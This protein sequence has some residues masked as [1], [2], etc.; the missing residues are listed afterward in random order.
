MD[1]VTI[2]SLVSGIIS[3]LDFSKEA[4]DICQQLVKDGS[5][6]KHRS[7]GE[8]A[9]SLDSAIVDLDSPLDNCPSDTISREDKVLVDLCHRCRDTASVIRRQLVKLKK[10]GGILD[11]IKKTIQTMR[12]N[13]FI[14]QKKKEL[15]G[16]ER[17]LNTRILVRLDTRAVQQMQ[18]FDRLL[19]RMN[20]LSI[21]A[22]DEKSS[23]GDRNRSQIYESIMDSLKFPEI[24]SR[25]EQILD[26]YRTTYEWIFKSS[27]EMDTDVPS[28]WAS[29]MDWLTAST[30]TIYWVHGKAGSGKST[31]MSFIEQDD[32][33][34]SAL[35]AWTGPDSVLLT[36]SFFFWE[37]GTDMQK[38]VKGLL[39]SLLCQILGKAPELLTIANISISEAKQSSSKSELPA[40]HALQVWTERRLSATLTKIMDASKNTDTHFCFFID[41]LDEFVGDTDVLRDIVK[42]LSSY[43]NTEVCVSSRPEQAFLRYFAGVP[44]LRLQDLTSKDIEFYVNDRLGSELLDIQQK[45]Y[46]CK[47]NLSFPH[48]VKCAPGLIDEIVSKASGVFLWVKIVT[49]QLL[50]GL[51]D[52][53]DLIELYERLKELPPDVE[54]LYGHMLGKL[55]DSYLKESSRYF[56]LLIAS[57]LGPGP[58]GVTLFQMAL[59]SET[60]WNNVKKGNRVYFESDSFTNERVRLRSRILARCAGLVQIKNSHASADL[61]MLSSWIRDESHPVE[62]ERQLNSVCVDFR[63]VTFIHKSVFEFLY[64][65]DAFTLNLSETN[66]LLSLARAHLGIGFLFDQIFVRDACSKYGDIASYAGYQIETL[67]LLEAQVI[68]NSSEDS[69]VVAV[70]EIIGLTIPM[71]DSLDTK[72]NPHQSE[73]WRERCNGRALAIYGMFSFY[74]EARPSDDSDFLPQLPDEPSLWAYFGLLRSLQKSFAAPGAIID[75]NHILSCIVYGSMDLR[76][77]HMLYSQHM[78]LYDVIRQC[79]TN[80]AELK[81][82][83]LG[84]RWLEIQDKKVLINSAYQIITAYTNFTALLSQLCPTLSWTSHLNLIDYLVANG[85]ALESTMFSFLTP[86]AWDLE[87]CFIGDPDSLKHVARDLVVRELSLP[88]FLRR[89]ASGRDGELE[90]K[91]LALSTLSLNNLLSG[92]DAVLSKRIRFYGSYDPKSEEDDCDTQATFYRLNEEQSY[93]MDSLTWLPLYDYPLKA[94]QDQISPKIPFSA[95]YKWNDGIPR[96][97]SV[98]QIEN[99]IATLQRVKSSLRNDQIIGSTGSSTF[100]LG[101]ESTYVVHNSEKAVDTVS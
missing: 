20:Q 72:L 77:E 15:E 43:Q 51:R 83:V 33:T 74:D 47:A 41:G 32:R 97:W 93:L 62:I 29:F 4:I 76:N 8:M 65:Q 25:Q 84:R 59:A 3:V 73:G 16:Y 70:D 28:E 45:C 67:A 56:E 100:V 2:F 101:D 37:S 21:G 34:A 6:S 78:G 58:Y 95:D 53:D 14:E 44:Q 9:D 50:S 35:Q 96:K 99:T 52:G 17:L 46:Q 40:S 90:N 5:V 85:K 81:S 87:S 26:A 86:S 38:S 36:P 55:P 13:E 88:L 63:E 11:V 69:Q 27:E 98:V 54:R 7:L 22:Q 71:L 30:G 57:L 24:S 75:W 89:F 1:P 23:L 12:K 19:E 66:G 94:S 80:G 92:G 64:N 60:S 82:K 68:R 91:T 39:Q 49:K 10:D 48:H 61:A 79:V 31:L 18:V 42:A